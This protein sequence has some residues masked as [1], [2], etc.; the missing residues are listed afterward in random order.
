MATSTPPQTPH[1]GSPQNSTTS[2]DANPEMAAELCNGV[3]VRLLRRRRQ[4]ADLHVVD[5]A[6]AQ[7]ADLSDRKLLSGEVGGAT[8]ASQTG[9]LDV[10]SALPRSGFVVC[11]A[12]SM[13]RR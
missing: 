9:C 2:V 7:R 8:P 11:R 6:P 13:A 10:S 5:H 4:I 3:E 12:C 1:C